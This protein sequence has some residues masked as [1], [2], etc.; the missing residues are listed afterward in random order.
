MTEHTISKEHMDALRVLAD[1]N[2]EISKAKELLSGLKKTE[3]EYL[4]E[5]EGKA[6]ERIAQV[7]E[8]S[9]VL[10]AET[11]KNYAEAHSLSMEVSGFAKFLCEAHKDLDRLFTTFKEKQDAWDVEVSQQE[12]VIALIKREVETDKVTIANDKKGI[13]NANKKLANDRRKLE[14]ERGTL[15]RAINRLKQGRI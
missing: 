5:R 14:D 11:A 7:L 2:V 10:V 4:T 15:E 9:R 3:S 12:A 8:D 13:E 6:I 1:T